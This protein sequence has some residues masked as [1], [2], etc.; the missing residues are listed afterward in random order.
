MPSP[1][2]VVDVEDVRITL[3][4]ALSSQVKIPATMALL[5]ER[6]GTIVEAQT[7]ITMHQIDIVVEDLYDI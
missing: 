6:V 3:T 4:V 5:R 2:A 7:A 1:R